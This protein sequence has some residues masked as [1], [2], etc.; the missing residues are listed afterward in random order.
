MARGDLVASGELEQAANQV[1]KKTLKELRQ[2][3][4]DDAAEMEHLISVQ[5]GNQAMAALQ[6]GGSWFDNAAVGDDVKLPEGGRAAGSPGKNGGALLS[7]DDLP[8]RGQHSAMVDAK[9][10]LKMVSA[11]GGGGPTGI[12]RE[13]EDQGRTGGDKATP[14]DRA[15]IQKIEAIVEVLYKAREQDQSIYQIKLGELKKRLVDVEDELAQERLG[16]VKLYA[17]IVFCQTL[18]YSPRELYE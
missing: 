17:P 6:Q 12:R 16:A 4:S 1:W 18:V 2:A 10:G 14:Q 15:Y 8:P 7:T 9:K 3:V 13:A 5:H 11:F